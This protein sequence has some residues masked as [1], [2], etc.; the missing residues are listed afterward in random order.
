MVACCPVLVVVVVGHM[1][2]FV[3]SSHMFCM[4]VASS[5]LE[6]VAAV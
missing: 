6:G 3:V 1:L 5:V 4:A 2:G